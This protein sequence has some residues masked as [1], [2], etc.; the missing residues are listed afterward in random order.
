MTGIV[1]YLGN[2]VLSVGDG[3]FGMPLSVFWRFGKDGTLTARNGLRLPAVPIRK[4]E[5]TDAS[6]LPCMMGH[7]D[8]A[9]S[10]RARRNQQIVSADRRALT[11][12]A[13]AQLRRHA[14]IFALDR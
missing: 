10:E 1:L 4:S 9:A 3:S 2:D 13:R 14:R 5:T 12:Q 7:D 11:I 6:K 8:E